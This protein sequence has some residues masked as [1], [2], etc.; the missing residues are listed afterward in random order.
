MGGVCTRDE[1]PGPVNEE[2]K[3]IGQES[4]VARVY[5]HIISLTPATCADCRSRGI[6]AVGAA[7]RQFS[8]TG[9][10]DVGRTFWRAVGRARRKQSLGVVGSVC[11]DAVT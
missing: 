5:N 10:D 8:A 7:Q 3:R 6:G 4:I 11:G 9:R 2:V 1:V